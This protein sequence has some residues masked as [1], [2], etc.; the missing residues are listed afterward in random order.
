MPAAAAP[1]R[2]RRPGACPAPR[3]ARAAPG[4]P[5][6]AS[7]R[8]RARGTRRPPPGR[9]APARGR[10]SAP[11]RRRRPRRARPSPGRGARRGDRD[12]RSASVASAS[13]R[14]TRRR[15][16]G[17]APVDRRAHQ[18][19]PEA[20][21]GAELDQARLGRRRR[22]AAARSRARR[23]PSTPAADRPPARPP[24]PGA[25]AASPAAA[26]P[27]APGSSPRCGPTAP[28][29]RQPEPARQ[30]GGRPARGSSS[31][32]SG[33]PRSRPRSDRARARRADPRPRPPAAPAHPRRPARRRRAPAGRREPLAG[34]LAHGEHQPDRLRAQPARHERQRLRR[35][36]V[37][38]LR[39]V[40]DAD[41]RPLLRRVGQQAQ[42]PPGRRGSDPGRRRRAG[43]T[44]AERLALRAGE[45]LEAIHE[46]RAELMQPRERELHLRLDA[47]RARDAAPRR[48]L[49]QVLQQRALA[50]AGLAAQHQRAARTRAHA[51]HQLIQRRALA[52]P[53]EQPRPGIRSTS[54]PAEA[55]TARPVGNQGA[56]TRAYPDGRERHRG[57]GDHATPR[58]IGE[59]STTVVHQRPAGLKGHVMSSIA[60]LPTRGGR[61]PHDDA[62]RATRSTRRARRLLGQ[63][64]GYVAVTVGFAA[65][66][67]Y[68]GRDLSGGPGCCCSSPRSQPSSDS[69]SP[70]PRAASNSR[71]G[72]CSGSACC[73]GS[74]SPRSSPTTP[75]ADPSAPLAGGRRHRG[76]RRRPRRVRLRHARDLVA[77]GHARCSGRCWA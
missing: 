19:M 62:L 54:P 48:A 21:L 72:S 55:R 63:V 12:R 40:H 75:S 44:R 64:M 26:P 27:A 42:R 60:T 52:A 53:A 23:P 57:L 50:D 22:R 38:P 13:A 41:Q 59:P 5:G 47:R 29:R 11:A 77:V 68:L 39:I 24:R 4:A 9:R 2:A 65:L 36:A 71:S 7:A 74:R 73:S 15:S 61:S 76:V 14:W 3:R 1:R 45:P 69:T 20:H 37:E 28:A 33:L 6:R 66:G 49:H 18:R 58:S 43:R 56:Q 8:R 17:A 30:L 32:A 46:R 51:R 35:G 67:A 34:R 31:S 70:S 25:A 16:S 10:P